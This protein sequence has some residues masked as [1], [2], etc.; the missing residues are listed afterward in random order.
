MI[1]LGIE[2]IEPYLSL[3]EGKRVGLIT[4]PTGVDQHFKTTIEI[5]KEKTNLVSLFSPEHG[6]RGNVQAGV[7][8]D[9]YIDPE[10]NAMVYSLYGE[11][12]RPTEA[13]MNE[14][15]ILCFDIQDVGARFY[16]YIYTMSFALEACKT[17]GK[18]MVIFDRPNPLG[19]VTVEG[20]LLDLNFRSFV[21]F[22]SIPQRYGLTIGELANY[23]NQE[24]H[25][26]ADL[27]V[28]PM[29]G[30]KRSMH[31][32]DTHCPFVL[33]SP[34][35]PT[36]ETIYAYLTTCY[37]EGTNLS[38]GRG[39]TKPFQLF[40]APW[41]NSKAMLKALWGY[42]LKGVTFRKHY[43]TP[44]FSKHQ[45]VLC[46]GLELYVTDV[47]TFEPVKTGMILLHLIKEIHPEF[48][49][50]QPPK[51]GQN[52]FF[53]LLIGDDFIENNRLSLDQII[54]KMRVDQ[55]AFTTVKERYHLYDL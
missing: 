44:T 24:E 33:P 23:F 10:T 54:E 52:L 19:G 43:F 18:K 27:T 17:Y 29:V 26:H 12:R 51:T 4:N 42:H 30:Y 31:Y 1:K 38:E 20:N 22:Y 32:A 11:T 53:N 41:F 9:P 2:N 35:I 36:Q 28:I 39:T 7:K 40:G 46:E 8:L 21:G 34:N 47:H 49:L 55:L 15:D 16:T 3:F 48:Q 6:V 14:I 45:N 37:F 13:M 25:I 5:L 50:I